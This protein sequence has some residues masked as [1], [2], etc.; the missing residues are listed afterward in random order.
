MVKLSMVER[1]NKGRSKLHCHS[2][3]KQGKEDLIFSILVLL[4]G[5]LFLSLLL[6][7]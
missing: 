1:Q 2:Y 6:Q 5:V 4:S 7:N 3:D